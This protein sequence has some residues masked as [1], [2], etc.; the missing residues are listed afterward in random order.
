MHNHLTAY[1][2]YN[3][4]NKSIVI[5]P[6][7]ASQEG[8]SA[9]DWAQDFLNTWEQPLPILAA[10]SY[11]ATI[12]SQPEWPNIPYLIETAFNDT[13]KAGVKMYSG[14]L[15][16]SPPEGTDL[17]DEMS[18]IK[19]V[20]DLSVFNESIAL[21]HSQGRPFILGTW[22]SIILNRSCVHVTHR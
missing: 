3:M 12:P 5:P 16:A 8:T 4:W 1:P 13:V 18:H 2:V 10:G 14:H 7:N 6:W 11:A 9:A 15:Y 20:A 22:K 19:T 17:A 21:S